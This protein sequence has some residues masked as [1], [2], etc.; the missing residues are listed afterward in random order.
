MGTG[1]TE[2]ANPADGGAW[3]YASA[4]G[5]SVGPMDFAALR[6]AVLGGSVVADTAVWRESFGSKWVAAAKVPELRPVWMEMERDRVRAVSALPLTVRPP[7][8]AFREALGVTS[9]ALF[10]PFTFI[11]WISLAFCNMMASTR[12]MSGAGAAI[13]PAAISA[14]ED[15]G[16]NLVAFATSFR[17]GIVALFEP[18]VSLAWQA[19]ILL[20]GLLVAFICAKGRLLF[21]GKAFSPREPI[22]SIWRKGLGRTASLVRLYYI[23]DCILNFGFHAL[24][25]AFFIKSGLHD[26]DVTREALS[27]AFATAAAEKYLSLAVLLLATVEFI[28]SASF[29][30]VEPLVFS[31]GVPVKVAAKMVLHAAVSRFGAFVG[32]FAIVIGCRIAYAATV[33]LAMS[34]LPA[35]LLLPLGLILLLP[36]DFLIRVLGT[37]FITT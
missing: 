13:Q 32:F 33:I 5:K 15:S 14:T 21:V 29:H 10:R 8:V 28:R 2:N 22:P 27:A 23:L 17:D 18:S 31:L 12:L 24:I 11:A 36:F 3:Y 37:R 16:T 25:Y 9:A 20:Y 7:L 34:V 19:N 4:D 26:G 1:Q 30:F 6:Q 35:R